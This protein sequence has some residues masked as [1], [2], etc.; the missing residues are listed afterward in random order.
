VP[1]VVSE[2]GSRVARESRSK[3]AGRLVQDGE[4]LFFAQRLPAAD[5]LENV[6]VVREA[7]PLQVLELVYAA[8]P[9]ADLALVETAGD[10]QALT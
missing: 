9:T 1:D 4:A 2:G 6:L 10:V 7:C 8:E 3:Q 5:Q